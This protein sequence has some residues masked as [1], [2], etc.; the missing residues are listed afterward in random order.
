MQFKTI[1]DCFDEFAE[2]MI[3]GTEKGMTSTPKALV[4]TA[5][6]ACFSLNLNNNAIIIISD[7]QWVEIRI[8]TSQ[9]LLLLLLF[10]S[11]QFSASGFYMFLF[12]SGKLGQ[13]EA[14]NVL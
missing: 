4:F 14:I 5:T 1:D 3:G 10:N 9:I 7:Q 11:I 6:C 2:K 8:L 12:G 13:R